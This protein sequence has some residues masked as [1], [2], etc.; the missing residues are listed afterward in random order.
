MSISKSHQT[1]TQ[2]RSSEYTERQTV[3]GCHA[4][5]ALSAVCVYFYPT[6]TFGPTAGEA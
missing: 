3:S 1:F 5:Q 2:I 6:G 4:L